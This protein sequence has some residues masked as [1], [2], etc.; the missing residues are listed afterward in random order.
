MVLPASAIMY[1]SGQSTDNSDDSSAGG[2]T[3]DNSGSSSAGGGTTT[4]TTTDNSSSSTGGSTTDNS[5]S[6]SA[7]GGTTTTTTTDN[8]SSS[9]GGSTG[10]SITLPTTCDKLVDQA[11]RTLTCANGVKLTLVGNGHG[12]YSTV[13]FQEANNTVNTADFI[14]TI[15]DVHNRERAAIGVP[16]L[17]WSDDLAAGAKTWAEHLATTGEFAHDTSIFPKEGENLASFGGTNDPGVG[18]S[19][20][21]DEKKNWN[22]SPVTTENFDTWLNKIGHYVQVVSP[23][24]TQVGCATAGSILD[25][26]YDRAL[27]PQEPYIAQ[28]LSQGK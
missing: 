21:V 22:G 10:N 11:G 18:I 5:G 27:F 13:P 28:F 24:T 17:T 14:K 26:R 1:A 3:T 20:W 9:T 25:C 4:T 19:A 12:G 7:G 2:S 8:S 15:L 6:S 16:P 23:A